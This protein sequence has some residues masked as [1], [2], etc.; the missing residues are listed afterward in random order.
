MKPLAFL[1]W[2]RWPEICNVEGYRYKEPLE[3][4]RGTISLASVRYKGRDD[5]RRKPSAVLQ[6]DDFQH[7]AAFAGRE[8]STRGP[9]D[10]SG[11][12]DLFWSWTHCQCPRRA[13]Y[14]HERLATLFPSNAGGPSHGAEGRREGCWA[15]YA[16]PPR[17]WRVVSLLVE[18]LQNARVGAARLH[19]VRWPQKGCPLAPSSRYNPDA[20]TMSP[21]RSPHV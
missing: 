14:K 4:S 16:K 3:F 17:G 20:Q 1:L 5:V 19:N 21:T 10:G 9:R 12:A 6:K 2:C 11:I 15:A 8:I 13:Q 7:E 18:T